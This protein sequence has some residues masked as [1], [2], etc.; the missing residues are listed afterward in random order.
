MSANF[1]SGMFQPV[2]MNSAGTGIIPAAG[3]KAKFYEAGTAIP[4]TIYTDPGFLVPYA[5]PSNIAFLDATGKALI[6]LGVGGYK[7]VLTDPNDVPVP[8]YTIDNIQAVGA[9]GT[10]FVNSFE[11]LEAVNT[12]I[13]PYTYIGGYYEQGDGGHGMFYNALS[14]ADPDG[15]YVQTSTFDTA[16]RWFRIP[17]ESG[18]VRAAAFG[19]CGAGIKTDSLLAADTYASSNG[20]ALRIGYYPELF[21]GSATLTSA[22]VVFDLYGV[23]RSTEGDYSLTVAGAVEAGGWQIFRDFE[24][25]TLSNP[26]QE[27]RVDWFGAVQSG[28]GAASLN[29]ACFSQWKAAGAG[30]FVVPPGSWPHDGAFTPSTTAPTRFDGAILDGDGPAIGIPVGLFYP[31]ANESRIRVGT[32]LVEDIDATQL[33]VDA[34]IVNLNANVDGN[35]T[36]ENITA[37]NQLSGSSVVGDA[38]ASASTITAQTDVIANR[39]LTAKAGNSGMTYNAGGVGQVAVGSGDCTLPAN[40]VNTQW[41]VMRITCAGTTDSATPTIAVT[42]G[43]ATVFSAT[44]NVG[45][46]GVFTY[47]ITV[48]VIRTGAASSRSIG[49]VVASY[50]SAP[51][52]TAFANSQ[53]AAITWANSNT[54]SHSATGTNVKYLTMYELLPYDGT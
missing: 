20:L 29:P 46:G 2:V 16:K 8:G 49:S 22:R 18:D 50:V 47:S 1:F 51:T 28:T 38:V 48:T 3:Y 11:E 52:A 31:P 36:A 42:V 33:D 17:D 32:L 4:K 19:F 35:I 54:I 12:S 26:T 13:F 10:G 34:L 25:V 30:L 5:S 24:T 37:Q 44:L 45:A 53:T 41:G 40:A 14:S 39:Y 7:L 27:S 23:L 21:T 6:Y 9:F 15:G 43:G